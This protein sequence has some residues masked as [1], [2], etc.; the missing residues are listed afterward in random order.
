MDKSDP[1]FP[2]RA[3]EQQRENDFEPR[4]FPVDCLMIYAHGRL[5]FKVSDWKYYPRESSN[6][7]WGREYTFRDPVTF[8]KIEINEFSDE[9]PEGAQ[10]VA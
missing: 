10:E 4:V 9:K 5:D 6:G 7:F 2:I 3:Y 1:A 8:R